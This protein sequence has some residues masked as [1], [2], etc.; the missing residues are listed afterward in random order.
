MQLKP[1]KGKFV[2]ATYNGPWKIF[3]RKNEIWWTERPKHNKTKDF[4]PED[5]PVVTG[6]DQFDPMYLFP[7]EFLPP[8]IPEGEDLPE[9]VAEMEMEETEILEPGKPATKASIL[10]LAAF[11]GIPGNEQQSV[12]D[13]CLL[14][15][16][17]KALAV[18]IACTS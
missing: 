2:L 4:E 11:F 13:A 5:M 16:H 1:G 10:M 3:G 15:Q 6:F 12:L 9:E 7:E 8:P 18:R 14:L 17:Y